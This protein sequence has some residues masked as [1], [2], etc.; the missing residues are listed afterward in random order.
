[1]DAYETQ[2]EKLDLKLLKLQAELKEVYSQ[3][4]QE[5]EL[6]AAKQRRVGLVGKMATVDIFAETE[7][8]LELVLIY[9]K[10]QSLLLTA[11]S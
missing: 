9:G 1:M 3:I 5:Q 8:K 11:L 7:G 10:S 2:A 6:W 4:S